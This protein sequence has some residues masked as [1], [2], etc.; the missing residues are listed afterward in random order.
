VLTRAALKRTGDGAVSADP[1]P[2]PQRGAR[3]LDP[4]RLA[5]RISNHAT[6]FVLRT[7]GVCAQALTVLAA[8]APPINAT[9]APLRAPAS[10]DDATHGPP[11]IT[12]GPAAERSLDTAARRWRSGPETAFGRAHRVLAVARGLLY[13]ERLCVCRARPAD[14]PPRRRRGHRR[15]QRPLGQRGGV[16]IIAVRPQLGRGSRQRVN[17]TQ[18]PRQSSHLGHD[19]VPQGSQ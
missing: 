19:E 18:A 9:S 8:T 2:L 4:T 10:Q 15:E 6:S 1:E 14:R 7:T 3:R 13:D 11:A 17:Q 16:Q 12:P 5:K